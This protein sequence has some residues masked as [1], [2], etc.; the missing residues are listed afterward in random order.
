LQITNPTLVLV[1]VQFSTSNY[2]DEATSGHD[3]DY[4]DDGWWWNAGAAAAE[5][6]YDSS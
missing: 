6:V 3:D 4:G 1:G 5:S 2:K